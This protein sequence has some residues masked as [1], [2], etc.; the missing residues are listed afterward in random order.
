MGHLS[1]NCPL[2]GCDSSAQP[3][4]SALRAH[5]SPPLPCRPAPGSLA[6]PLSG[7][8]PP[9]RDRPP[10][11]APP[12]RCCS[13]V[14][15]RGGGPQAI[16]IGKNCDKFGIVV[17]ELGHVVGFWHEHTR[18]DRDRHVSIVRENI[19]P[20]RY[21]PLGAASVG[22]SRPSPHLQGPWRCSGS[23]YCP[24][25]SPGPAALPAAWVQ[26][27]PAPKAF[28]PPLQMRDAHPLWSSSGGLGQVL[29]LDSGSPGSL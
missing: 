5:P 14:G 23:R 9:A 27:A 17:H 25:S 1:R 2:C 8:T 29:V 28:P 15:R 11:L 7:C 18:P 26:P 20:G 10:E 6:P 22:G 16:S 4:H 3:G 13:Y 12:S 24:Q 21:L 19:Q